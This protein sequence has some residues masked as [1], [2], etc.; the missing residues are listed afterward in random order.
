M[1]TKKLKMAIGMMPKD[2]ADYGAA[3]VALMSALDV[4]DTGN[5]AE[6]IVEVIEEILRGIDQIECDDS[7][8]VGCPSIDVLDSMATGEI[9][10]YLSHRPEASMSAID[11][12][13]TATVSV[14]GPAVILTVGI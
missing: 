3:M 11:E 10:D 13:T 12:L 9:V 5:Q 6:N 7:P 8:T 4:E 1:I 14:H 2:R